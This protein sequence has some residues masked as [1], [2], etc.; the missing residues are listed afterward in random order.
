MGDA[1]HNG[2][3][4]VVGVGADLPTTVDDAVAVGDVLNDAGRCAY[5]PDQVEV[6]TGPSATRDGVL[7][8]LGRLAEASDEE[9][10]VI[11]YFSGHGC[12][13]PDGTHHLLT[14]GYDLARPAETTI[15]GDELAAALAAIRGGRLVLVLDC[16]HAGGLDRTVK[17]L[18]PVKVPLPPEV[19]AALS[20]GRGRAVIAS[21]AEGELSYAGT[22]YSEFTLA[23]LEAFA[24]AGAGHLDGYVRLSDLALYT[25]QVVAERTQDRQHPILNF[26]ESDNF[27][28]SYY[29]AGDTEPKGP[30]VRRGAAPPSWD[31]GSVR[32]LVDDALSDDDVD[33]LCLDHFPSVRRAF[34]AGMSRRAKIRVLVDHATRHDRLADVVRLVADANPE[35]YRRHT[36]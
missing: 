25:R 24:G 35:M 12:R 8:A 33:D 13:M 15:T 17:G 36:R 30:P 2:H 27:V 29:A 34:A 3:A 21:S 14:H 26:F 10:T 31:A 16:C 32:R 23:L 18:G 4:L 20:Q 11:V 22:P 7:A 1:F 5:P 9:S 19:R 6:L 28:L